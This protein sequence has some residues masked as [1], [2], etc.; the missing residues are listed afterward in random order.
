[1]GVCREESLCHCQ[2]QKRSEDRNEPDGGKPKREPS[3]ATK[4]ADARERDD[5]WQDDQYCA[6][7]K[8]KND[9]RQREA[10][11]ES[12]VLR[13][14]I[15]GGSD[16]KESDG[17]SQHQGIRPQK[18]AK[19]AK[20]GGPGRELHSFRRLSFVLFAFLCGYEFHEIE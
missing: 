19:G 18:G 9:L 16:S 15:H 20:I 8:E 3:V 11:R 2:P 12:E 13:N 5:Q 1:M 6:A 17:A 10:P 7:E 4:P 14:F